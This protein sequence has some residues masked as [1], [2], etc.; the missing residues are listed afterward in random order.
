MAFTFM[1]ETAFVL[2]EMVA[3]AALGGVI[4]LIIQYRSLRN[5]V[6]KLEEEE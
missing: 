4:V 3:G 2:T 1:T 6:K 5:R